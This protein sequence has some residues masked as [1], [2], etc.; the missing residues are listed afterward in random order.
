[1]GK[2]KKERNLT[3]IDLQKNNKSKKRSIA[4][5]WTTEKSCLQIKGIWLKI[6]VLL[7]I[8]FGQVGNPTG[9]SQLPQIFLEC[10]HKG[11][12]ASLL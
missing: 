11:K 8:L 12:N 10:V 7:C 3:R 5:T 4:L 9:Q 1:M 6:Q 2:E